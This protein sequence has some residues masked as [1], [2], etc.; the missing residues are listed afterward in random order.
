[1]KQLLTTQEIAGIRDLSDA[2]EASDVHFDRL[3]LLYRL[4]KK[5]GVSS[6]GIRT[7][8]DAA[9]CPTGIAISADGGIVQT[10]RGPQCVRPACADILGFNTLNVAN[11]PVAGGGVGVVT[12]TAA[13]VISSGNASAYTATQF[14][15]EGRNAAAGLANVPCLLSDVSVSGIDQLVDNANTSGITS[16]VFALTN[17]PLYVGWDTF[18]DRGAK[19]LSLTFAN[20]LAVAVT[21][22]IFGV[23]WGSRSD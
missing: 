6:T 20:I 1:M 13:V 8:T 5:T 21:L 7:S 17:E 16:A 19:Q 3:G 14:F 2:Q 23:L 22:E 15:F 9:G 12:N 11:F 4:L 18:M 10:H